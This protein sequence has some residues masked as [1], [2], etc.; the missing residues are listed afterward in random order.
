[1]GVLPN[2]IENTICIDP[3][4]RERTPFEEL[5]LNTAIWW[6][7]FEAEAWQPHQHPHTGRIILNNIHTD[8]FRFNN[9][10]TIMPM[11]G[12]LTGTFPFW[13]HIHHVG[14]HYIELK[15]ND[16][17]KKKEKEFN[18][19]I[20]QIQ[21]YVF[22]NYKIGYILPQVKLPKNYRPSS[23]PICPLVR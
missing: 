21:S 19:L 20:Y 10:I 1:M 6:N 18:D 7:W 12:R 17:K 13:D 15:K 9:W 8:P 2:S 16:K 23:A 14:Y 3:Y 11:Q 5:T 4:E 22:V